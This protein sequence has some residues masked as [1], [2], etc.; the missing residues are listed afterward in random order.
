MAFCDY[1]TSTLGAFATPGGHIIITRGL[2]KHH[3]AEIMRQTA[4]VARWRCRHNR[5]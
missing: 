5:T 1:D 3:F 2:H 4:N